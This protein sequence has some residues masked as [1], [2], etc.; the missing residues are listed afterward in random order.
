MTFEIDVVSGELT[1]NRYP[2]LNN[3]SP[4]LKPDVRIKYW[5]EQK[6]EEQYNRLFIEI[7]S[8]EELVELMTAINQKIIIRREDEWDMSVGNLFLEIY[9]GWRE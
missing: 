3:Y 5:R 6:Y 2:Q 4:M 8:I 9:D 1:L 7:K